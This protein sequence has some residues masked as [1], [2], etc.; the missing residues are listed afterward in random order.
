MNTLEFHKSVKTLFNA[1]SIP[2]TLEC[3][4]EKIGGPYLYFAWKKHQSALQLLYSKPKISSELIRLYESDPS[5]DPAHLREPLK[6]RT[7]QTLVQ[8]VSPEEKLFP[9]WVYIKQEPFG[10]FFLP[11]DSLN[12]QDLLS[13]VELKCQNLYLQKQ[14]QTPQEEFLKTLYTEISRSRRLSLPVSLILVQC[15]SEEPLEPFLKSLYN[16]L[17][18]TSRI[19]DLTSILNEKEIAV[20]LP[21]TSERGG[22]AKAEKIYWTLQSLNQTEILKK[23]VHF[24]IA[25]A[26]YPKSARSAESLFQLARDACA[27]GKSK[28]TGIVIAEAPQGFKPDFQVQNESGSLCEWV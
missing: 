4:L 2:K 11:D 18:K 21:H 5:F 23:P 25:I 14:A 9:Y 7:L 16:H 13:Y 12:T 15:S 20:L 27:F 6:I 24:Q 8:K 1:S 10:L 19:Y 17:K 22:L 26:E 28:Q 3:L